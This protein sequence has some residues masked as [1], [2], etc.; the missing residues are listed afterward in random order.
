MSTIAVGDIHGNLLALDDLL[1]RITKEIGP[2]DTVVFLGDYID[3]GP[4]SK[5]CIQ[6]ILDF[7][8]SVAARVVALLGNHEEW[9]L[10]THEDYTRHS[11]LLGMEGFATVRSYSPGAAD[12]LREEADEL[13]PRMVLERVPLSY[14]LFFQAVPYEHIA[15]L[16]N[17]KTFCRTPDAVCVHG[18]LNPKGGPVEVQLSDDLTWGGDGFPQEYKGEEFVLY[19][20]ADHPVIDENGWPHPRI[21][22]RTY[23]LDTISKGVL[24]TFRLPERLVLQSNRFE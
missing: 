5:G 15:F 18:G 22:G 1:D 2:A 19:G 14:E 6:R 8:V 7:Q 10:R 21:L 17:L 3:R 16:K 13:G 9:M 24:T 23:G 12:R 4:D 20:H 11:W